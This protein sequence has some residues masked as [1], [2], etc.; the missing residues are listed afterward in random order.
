MSARL[1]WA[2]SQCLCAV[3]VRTASTRFDAL[4]VDSASFFA[5]TADDIRKIPVRAGV[6]EETSDFF[7][8]RAEGYV[9]LPA[10]DERAD[11]GAALEIPSA[12]SQRNRH[13]LSFSSPLLPPRGGGARTG[14]AN[15]TS[16]RAFCLARWSPCGTRDG[17]PRTALKHELTNNGE[18]LLI[19]GLDRVRLASALLRLLVRVARL[20]SPGSGQ[21][22]R[23]PSA[24]T[25]A[26]IARPLKR[27]LVHLRL[28]TCTWDW[29][30]AGTN[31]VS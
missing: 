1:R 10:P 3:T 20:V 23:G 12:A 5:V 22:E 19:M 6:G 16:L 11:S 18:L 8:R 17:H 24:G 27:R 21:H 14:A 2:T 7:M 25:V 26:P 28:C 30:P 29:L 31:T 13:A 9:P 4:T 15:S